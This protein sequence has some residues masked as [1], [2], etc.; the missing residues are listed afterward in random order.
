[1]VKNAVLH[2][3]WMYR[4]RNFRSFRQY[5]ETWYYP[6][7]AFNNTF[8]LRRLL[9]LWA[10]DWDSDSLENNLRLLGVEGDRFF[11]DNLR[12]EFAREMGQ[13]NR[14][15]I[16]FYRA[17][18]T[19]SNGERSYATTYDSFFGDVTRI[20]IIYDK[21]F[22]M[23]SFL[24]LWPADW[25][26]WDD[27]AYLAYYEGNRG[28]AQCYSDSLAA[29]LEMLGGAYD[30]YPWFLPLAV[31]VFAQDT[32]NINFG[33]PS[34]KEWIGFR[35]FDRAEDM[36]EYFG[37]DPRSQ[38]HTPDGIADDCPTA[39]LGPADDGHQ[40][41]YDAAGGQWA[42]LY[43]D[44]RNQHLCASADMSPAS[45][46]LLRD[47]NEA[48]NIENRDTAS[49]YDIKYFLDFYQYFD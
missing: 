9:E 11:F 42:Y 27:Y 40:T 28:D 32:H 41:F 18:L 34:M 17:I 13:A 44:D 6:D 25:Y 19:Q 5:W 2:Y 37:F 46:K 45:H 35:A 8:W 20:G 49:T 31:E 7:I 21:F 38:C 16:N 47:Y 26:N 22:A 1:M 4:F 10:L 43:L 33:D 30:V 36:A 15:V 23:L 12:D 29:V 14:M 39:A 24:G 3:D 48:V